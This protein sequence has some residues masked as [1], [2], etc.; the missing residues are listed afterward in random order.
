M[1]EI[2]ELSRIEELADFRSAW[3]TLLA[4]TRGAS[5]FQTLEWLE[6]YWK[7][8]GRHEKLRVLIVLDGA[9]PMGIVPLVV[10][11]E[12]TRLGKLRTL[13]YPLHDWGSFYGPIGRDATATLTLAM[14]HVARTRRDWELL[15]FRFVERDGIDVARTPA[16]LE[17][18]GLDAYESSWK[19]AALLDMTGGWPAYWAS[20]DH[21]FRNNVR[22]FQRRLAELGE[23]EHIRYRPRGE[24]H[25]ESDP[26]WDLYDACVAVARR[27]WQGQSSNGTTLSHESVRDF[28][29]ETHAVAARLGCVDLN[30]IQVNGQPIAFGY[31]YVYNQALVGLR[32]GYDPKFAKA[33]VGNLLY[34]YTFEDCF[35]RGDAQFDI[36]VGALEV[37]RWWWTHTVP[38]YRYTHYPLGAPRAQ[39]LRL[40][41]WLFGSRVRNEVP[42]AEMHVAG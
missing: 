25:G 15:D 27:S 20:R 34:H 7:H 19:E 21:K 42:L 28:L 26:R 14:Q 31:N 33:G 36:G 1:V 35:Q 39:L 3:H 30:L 17:A 11:R 4:T 40:K 8:Y 2:L 29:R 6:V 12:R 10:T 13:T 5:F 24:A 37:K 22:R 41:H 32:I 23:V 9:Q 18:A 38:S 16:A